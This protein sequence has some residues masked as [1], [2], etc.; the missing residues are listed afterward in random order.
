MAPLVRW[1]I[2]VVASFDVT[3]AWQS[4]VDDGRGRQDGGGVCEFVY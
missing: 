1:Q 2:D 3:V 4:L